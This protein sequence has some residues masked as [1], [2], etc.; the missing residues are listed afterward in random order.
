MKL[1]LIVDDD[2]L[3]LDLLNDILSDKYKLLFSDNAINAIKKSKNQKID[4][5]ITDIQMPAMSGRELVEKIRKFRPEIKILFI[6]G[7][8]TDKIIDQSDVDVNVDYIEK[9]FDKKSLLEKI[10]NLIN[11]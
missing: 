8:I 7:H 3:I 2:Q 9:P 10:E 5:L 6:S 1:I 11:E 4:L